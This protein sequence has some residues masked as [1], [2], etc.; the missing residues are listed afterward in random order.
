[1][2]LLPPAYKNMVATPIHFFLA[3]RSLFSYTFPSQLFET[4]CAKWNGIKFLVISKRQKNL[5]YNL[6]I[7][8]VCIESAKTPGTI[9]TS[10]S[11]Y[12]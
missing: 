5:D 9:Y 12:K 4:N 3:R 7:E 11:Y 6:C 8:E 1:L 10:F 2:T